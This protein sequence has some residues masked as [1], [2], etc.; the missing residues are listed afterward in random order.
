MVVCVRA[1][2]PDA[3]GEWSGSFQIRNGG[4]AATKA[5]L[6]PVG[7]DHDVILEPPLQLPSTLTPYFPPRSSW[8]YSVKVSPP[9]GAEKGAKDSYMLVRIKY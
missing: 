4:D 5:L 8:Q 2:Q 6:L 7:G 1:M 9:S 3:S